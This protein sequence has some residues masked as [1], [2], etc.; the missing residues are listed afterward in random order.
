M[1]LTGVGQLWVADITCIWLE[2]ELDYLAGILDAY[3]RRR[4]EHLLAHLLPL[5]NQ[6]ISG[7]T[8]GILRWRHSPSADTRR[9][10]VTFGAIL[11]IDYTEPHSHW[12]NEIT[13]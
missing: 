9:R 7:W 4:L 1:I 2:E 11:K 8:T 10:L 3:S 13:S 12:S 6:S 5:Q